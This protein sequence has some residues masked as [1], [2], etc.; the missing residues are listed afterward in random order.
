MKSLPPVSPTKR[1]YVRVLA[2]VL[3]DALPHAIENGRAAGEVN[4]RQLGRIDEDVRDLDRVPR[5]EVDDARRQASGFEHLERV[6]A[7]QHRGGSRLPNDR[8]AHE[9]RRGRQVPANR[10]E[11]EWR[12]GVHETFEVAILHLVPHTR[13]ADRLLAVELLGEP[14]VEAPE[15]DHLGCCVDFRLE[16]RLRLAE[17]CRRGDSGAPGGR[18]E[19]G[20]AQNDGGAILPRPAR[21]LAAPRGR[22]G[23]RLLHVL[24][25]GNVVLGQHVL[26]VVRHDRLLGLTRANFLSSDHEGYV[27]LL[28]CHRLQA[29]FQLGSLGA[30]RR[31]RAVHVVHGRRDAANAGKRGRLL[32]RRRL[33]CG[34]ILNRGWCSG[35]R[36]H[37]SGPRI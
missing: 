25:A 6:V 4:A 17:H 2:D 14:G 33:R 37:R 18:Q 13:A 9:G 28:R 20:G 30:A 21:P 1:G 34:R 36:C 8:V 27:D 26:V 24:G 5:Q 11:V 3:A 23:N 16:R 7:A 15:I 10:R 29:R 35:G 22:C 31:V 32:R 12:D 19:L